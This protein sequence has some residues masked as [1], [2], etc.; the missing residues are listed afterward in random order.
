MHHYVI[1]GAVGTDR[2]ALRQFL[3]TLSTGTSVNRFGGP[4]RVTR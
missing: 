3:A 4:H 1:R 2:A